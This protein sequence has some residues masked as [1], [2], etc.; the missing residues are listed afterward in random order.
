MALLELNPTATCEQELVPTFT[1]SLALAAE[2]IL[3]LANSTNSELLVPEVQYG[4]R[5]YFNLL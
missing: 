5:D 2:Y 1:L 3:D 4:K